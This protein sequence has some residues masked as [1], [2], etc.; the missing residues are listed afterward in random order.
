M[1]DRWVGPRFN[2]ESEKFRRRYANIYFN[3]F[4]HCFALY[5]QVS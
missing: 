3:N 4:Q 1:T 5:G 2:D